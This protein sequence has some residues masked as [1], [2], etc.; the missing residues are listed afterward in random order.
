M[1][2]I[3]GISNGDLRVID[4]QVPKAANVLSIQ[5]GALAY[6]PGFGIDLKYFLSEDFEFQNES[7]RAYLIERL[8]NSGVNVTSVLTTVNQLYNSYIFSV[9]NEETGSSLIAR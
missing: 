1:I 9:G 8:A 6:A 4:T 3:V 5:L 7:F 2:D